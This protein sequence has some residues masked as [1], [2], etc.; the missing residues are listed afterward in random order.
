MEHFE[1]FPQNTNGQNNIENGFDSGVKAS[2]SVF[3]R[4]T[5][6]CRKCTFKLKVSLGATEAHWVHSIHLIH[7]FGRQL[8]KY[9]NVILGIK[10]RQKC[11]RTLFKVLKQN[12][13]RRHWNTI[14]NLHML[15]ILHRTDGEPSEIMTIFIAYKSIVYWIVAPELGAGRGVGLSVRTPHRDAA[16]R[17]TGSYS[18]L[19]GLRF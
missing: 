6:T 2:K 8:K 12:H 1:D 3:Q 18:P 19:P 11:A 14:P 13:K 17:G 10:S 7:L 9:A 15:C 4:S 16:L 5:M